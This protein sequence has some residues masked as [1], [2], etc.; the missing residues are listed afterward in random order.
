MAGLRTRRAAVPP[1]RRYRLESA[2]GVSRPEWLPG[3][4]GYPAP[5]VPPQNNG[6]DVWRPPRP[7]DAGGRAELLHHTF[8]C[9]AAEEM[10]AARSGYRRFDPLSGSGGW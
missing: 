4:R 10:V 1:A 8:F 9:V 5:A 2:A 3:I 6:P 7:A